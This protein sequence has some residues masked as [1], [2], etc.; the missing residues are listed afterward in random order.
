MSGDLRTG[1]IRILK[2]DGKS[3][4]TGFILTNDGIIATCAHVIKSAEAGPGDKV[5]LVFHHTD[6]KATATV[7]PDGWRDPNAEDIAILRLETPLPAGIK[8]LPLASATGTASHN[9]ETF[10][11]PD[12]NPNEGLWGAGQILR[13]TTLSGVQVL[14]LQSQ[15]VTPGFSGA[16]VWD[17]THQRVVGMVTAITNPDNYGRLTETAFATP[18]EVLL[19][20]WLH[21]QQIVQPVTSNRFQALIEDKTKDFVGREYVFTAIDKFLVSQPNGYFVIEGDPGVGK[22]AIL[23]EYVRRTDCLAH[24][25]VRAQGLNRASQF[26]ES[27]CTQLIDRYNLPYPTLSPEA[28]QD[29]NFLAK[30]LDDIS[31]QLND[32]EWLV[33]AIDA[34]DEV[35]LL[36]HT[37][38]ANILYLPP[39]LPRG[40]YFVM[41]RRQVS[42]PFTV[43]VPQHLLDLMQYRA[44]SRA[45]VE[46]YLKRAV[47][48][49]EIRAWI[50]DRD[51]VL[52][53]FITTLTDKS[54]YNFM[55]LRYVLQ[56]IER[57]LYHDLNIE[58]LPAGLKGYYED[59]WRRMG[60][61]TKPLPKTK[62]KIVYILAEVREPVSRN[63][64]CDFSDED[65]LTVQE[66]LDEWD[67]FLHEQQIDSQTRYSVYHASF[68]DFLHRKDIVQAAG[69]TIK[70]INALIADDLWEDLFGDE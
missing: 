63:L 44:E 32:G 16:P 20:V 62:I 61:M 54:E 38:G 52:E 8:P 30:L 69:V 11:F 25:N 51:L 45:D 22:S 65:A 64:I 14:Q 41:T 43:H 4:G 13:Q 35:D 55:Y 46:I 2:K 39:L 33:I 36:G 31:A 18:V 70:E 21:L 47:D 57:G 67:Q 58:N 6:I 40:V 60:M 50:E 27:I 66:V 5:Q 34:L 56:D 53:T 59:H 42:L 19:E 1:I 28:T 26:L 17:T 48:Q 12:V 49:P 24:F 7:E 37:S 29:G 23:A 15:E 3:V 9:F 68:R 10:G